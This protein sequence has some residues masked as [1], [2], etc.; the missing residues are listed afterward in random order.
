M[1]YLSRNL[2]SRARPTP[3]KKKLLFRSKQLEPEYETAARSLLEYGIPLA[4]VDG[5]QEKE[6]AETLRIPG[7]PN[8]K[9]NFSF[10]KI[11]IHYPVKPVFDL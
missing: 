10:L 2:L 5:S 1:D 8:L 4:K 9:V 11:Q 6:I 3:I 7:W